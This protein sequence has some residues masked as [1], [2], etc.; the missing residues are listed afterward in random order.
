MQ[1]REVREGVRENPSPEPS[2][3]IKETKGD[4]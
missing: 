4:E 3:R 2:V 1:R